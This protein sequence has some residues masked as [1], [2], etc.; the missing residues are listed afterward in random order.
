MK[1][2][3]TLG[4]TEAFASYNNSKVNADKERLMRTMKD[5]FIW[6]REWTSHQDVEH[7]LAQWVER[8][9]TR[10][11]HSSLGYKTPRQFEQDYQSSHLT[12]FVAA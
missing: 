9:N 12:Q 7:A 8:Y 2:C 1:A 5:E 4:M 3:A 11:R 10:Y 6:L